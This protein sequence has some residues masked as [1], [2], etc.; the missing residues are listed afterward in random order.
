MKG[1]QV[2]FGKAV[3]VDMI[4]FWMYFNGNVKMFYR[5]KRPPYIIEY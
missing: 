1:K 3:E 4:N 5:I 2:S